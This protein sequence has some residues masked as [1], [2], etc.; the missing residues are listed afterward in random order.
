MGRVGEPREAQLGGLLWA[1]LGCSGRLWAALG[2]S[3]L[4][5]AALGGSGRLWAALG[6]SGLLWAA[7]G[8]SG[9]LWAA[10][11]CSVLLWAALACSG[12]LWAALNA[13]KI[14]GS[15]VVEFYSIKTGH[16]AL[17][18][19]LHTASYVVRRALLLMARSASSAPLGVPGIAET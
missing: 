1:A 15:L 8:C 17:C 19:N 3:G 14:Y 16:A 13:W 10:L 11:G 18:L 2:C 5:W 9:L 6:C 7:L 12:L 4:L